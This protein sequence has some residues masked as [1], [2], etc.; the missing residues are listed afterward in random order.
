MLNEDLKT[1]QSLFIKGEGMNLDKPMSFAAIVIVAA[2]MIGQLDRL[3]RWIRIAQ[4]KIIY[5]SRASNWESA[6]FFEHT[7]ERRNSVSSVTKIILKKQK[8]Q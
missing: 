3:Q 5:E 4:A 7:K 2:A 6:R 8:N 1:T